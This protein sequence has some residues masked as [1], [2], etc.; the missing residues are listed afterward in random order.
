MRRR[1]SWSCTPLRCWSAPASGKSSDGNIRQRT[2]RR[3]V[4]E[5]V[6]RP[7]GKNYFF[8]SKLKLPSVR[9]VS[10]PTACHDTVYLP[11]VNS[12]LT[13]T[14]NCA[15]SLAFKLAVPIGCAL[16]EASYNSIPESASSTASL[17]WMRIA[18]G[19]EVTTLPGAGPAAFSTACASATVVN[20]S[21]TAVAR[22]VSLIFDI[23]TFLS[24]R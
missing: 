18:L 5:P 24:L 12:P 17:N 15:L 19:E 20:A 3:E 7:P 16:P 6:D 9:C 22:I 13:G 1:K 4:Q 23:A 10:S 11:G 2:Q 21:T 14:I 8:T